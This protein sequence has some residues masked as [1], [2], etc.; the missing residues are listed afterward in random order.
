MTPRFLRLN[1]TVLHLT[2]KHC[3][4]KIDQSKKVSVIAGNIDSYGFTDGDGLNAQFSDPMGIAV[5]SKGDVYVADQLNKAVRKLV[6][7][8]GRD[9]WTVSTLVKDGAQ[10]TS[11]KKTLF[12]AING[13]FCD[14]SDNLYLAESRHGNV[15]KIIDNGTEKSPTISL[16]ANIS[17]AYDITTDS[18]NNIYIA[19]RDQICKLVFVDQDTLL[20]GTLQKTTDVDSD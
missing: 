1:L 13:L 7:D 3:I 6:Y 16:L 11:N 14:S 18:L 4:K 20:S 15:Y 9:K 2:D 12:T 19:T 5:N 17:S 10:T 8:S